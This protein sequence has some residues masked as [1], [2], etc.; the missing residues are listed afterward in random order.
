[1]GH[2]WFFLHSVYECRIVDNPRQFS[3]EFHNFAKIYKYVIFVGYYDVT[4]H[5][6]LKI[7]I[8]IVIVIFFQILYVNSYNHG[9][10]IFPKNLKYFCWVF[11]L[12]W[13][14]LWGYSSIVYDPNWYWGQVPSKWM[15]E[16]SYDINLLAT[17]PNMSSFV[18]RFAFLWGLFQTFIKSLF[19]ISITY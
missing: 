14:P 8:E 5:K 15:S 17:G 2:T 6:G 13:L 1:M 11:V 16:Q 10:F 3:L 12:E 7:E 19:L 4:L 18:D 9:V